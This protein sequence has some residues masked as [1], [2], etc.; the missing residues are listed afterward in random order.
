MAVELRKK[1]APMFR[2]NISFPQA[3]EEII[4]FWKEN[5]SFGQCIEQAKD[6]QPFIFY[7]GPPFATGLPHYGHILSGTIKDVIGRFWHQQGFKVDR[8]FGWDCHGLPVEYEIDKKLNITDRRQVLEMGID[9]YNEECRSIVMKYSSEWEAIVIRM[10]RWVD[11]RRGYKTMDRS[12]M[13]ST[14]FIFKQLWDRNKIYRGYKVMPFSTACK[15]PLSNFEAHQNYKE[16]SDPSVLVAFPLLEQFRGREVCLVAWTTTPWTLPSNCGLVVNKDFKY[17]IFEYKGKHYAIHTNRVSYY[18]KDV[19]IVDSCSGRDLVGLEYSQPFDFFESLR[20]KGFFRVISADFVSDSDGTAIVHCAPAFGEEDY[21]VFVSQ[22]LIRENDQ[23]PCPV[24]ENGCFTLGKYKGIYVKDLDK[25]ILQDIKERVLVNGRAVHSYPFCWRSDT[26]LIYKLVPNWFIKVRE[27]RGSLL[28]NNEPINWVPKDIKYK[29]FHNWLAQARDWAV[30]RNRFWGTPLPI[31]VTK[32]YEDMI[33]IGSVSEL[34]S[35]SGR[36]VEDLHR[37]YIDD[38]TITKDGKVYRRVDE[39]LDCW[40]ESGS[41][42]FSQDHWPFCLGEGIEKGLSKVSLGGKNGFLA[43]EGF[44]AQFIGEGLDQ[45]RGWFYT[46]HVISSLLFDKPAFENVIVNG[47]VLA[48]DGKKMSKRL[49][50]YP[51]PNEIFT[52]YGADSLRMYLI[53]SP[54]VEAENLR[55]SESGVREIMKVLL[56]PWYSSLSFLMDCE[57]ADSGTEM[58]GWITTSFN[59]FCFNVSSSVKSY[60]L[61]GVLE[62]A[63]KFIDDLSNWYIRINRRSIRSGANLLASLLQDFSIVMA[64][65]TPFFSEYCYR[66]VLGAKSSE[67]VHHCS[68]PVT[69]PSAHP[70]EKAKDVI[71]GIRQMREKLKLKVKR[72]IK[73]AKVVCSKDFRDTLAGFT[74]VIQSEC[75]LLEI[76]FEDESNFTLKTTVKPFFESLKQYRDTMKAKIDIIRSLSESQISEVLKGSVEIN[77]LE[78]RKADVLLVKEFIGVKNSEIFGEFGLVIDDEINDAIIELADAREF[79]SFIQKLRKNSGLSADDRVCIRISNDYIKSVVS[80]KYS[81]VIFGDN[82]SKVAE[83]KYLFKNEAL[84]VDLYRLN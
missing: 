46:L 31:W 27:S 74:R 54:V 79:Y 71:E 81:D 78:I 60:K 57:R 62:Y 39:V 49:K 80:K 53:S 35:L 43:K 21:K 51:D 37:Q 23:V 40:F 20:A 77:G 50:N 6:R 67:S 9:K 10:G 22:G 24:D 52:K 70:F 76:T 47:I 29:R 33:C 14:W 38:V 7:D 25:I 56:I 41:M 30:S 32:N 73:S 28:K 16:V 45:T 44:P 61:S 75:N 18:F 34:E 19:E 2:K 8:R 42:P 48:E 64:P 84:P 72:P 63:L 36:Q 26:P 66:S 59:N 4:R 11:F 5:D 83:S 17:D 1:F 65:F 13:E 15:T 68:Y 82:G 69:S 58:D 12:F 3:E 55:F